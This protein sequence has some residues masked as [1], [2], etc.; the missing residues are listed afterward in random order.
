[1]QKRMIGSLLL[2][3]LILILIYYSGKREV[4]Q[5]H[6]EVTSFP[7]KPLRIVSL[8][9]AADEILLS[10]VEKERIQALTYLALDPEISNVSS[11]ALGVRNHINTDAEKIIALQPD[12]VITSSFTPAEVVSMLE[13]AGVSVFVFNLSSSLQEIKNNIIS[14][15]QVVGEKAKGQ[16]LIKQ[17]EQQE[18]EII[19]KTN[20]RKHQSLR[21]LYYGFSGDVMGKSTQFDELAQKLGLRNAAAEAGIL[22]IVRLNK[23][24]LIKLNPDLIYI[25]K[26][27][28]AGSIGLSPLRRDLL[29]D[30]S[31]ASV[32]AVKHKRIYE[33]PDPHFSCFSQ[34]ILLGMEDLAR[35]A[36]PEAFQ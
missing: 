27:Q 36:Y 23:E 4:A 33:L 9:L 1:M 26:W 15:A 24:Q 19:R 34:Y 7:S 14:I 3:F 17:M 8:S 11:K 18:R 5:V 31:L 13:E 6:Q 20:S 28:V 29:Q 21:V 25:P 16:A 30:P 22:G 2:V 35:I 32:E 12:L 10:L